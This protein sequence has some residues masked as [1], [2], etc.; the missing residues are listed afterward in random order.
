MKLRLVTARDGAVGD[1]LCVKIINGN[2]YWM[3]IT[4]DELITILEI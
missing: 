4:I 1:L 2:K 3:F